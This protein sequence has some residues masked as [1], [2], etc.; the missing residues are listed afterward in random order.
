MEIP[1]YISGVRRNAQEVKKQEGRARTEETHLEND[2][3]TGN[4][5][6][7][8]QVGRMQ[9]KTKDVETGRERPT[10]SNGKTKVQKGKIKKKTPQCIPDGMDN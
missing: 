3:Q 4:G 7:S 9:I 5:E 8:E 10:L 1:A 2:Y 6:W